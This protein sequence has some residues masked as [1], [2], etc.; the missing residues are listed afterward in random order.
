MITLF[1]IVVLFIIGKELSRID[2]V[3]LLGVFLIHTVNIFKRRKKYK[4]KKIEDEKTNTSK[5]SWLLI[6]TLA[7]I[8]LFIAS[9]FVVKYASK[10]AF[11]LNLPEILI[12]LFLISFATTLPELVF[13]LSAAKLKHKE[14]AI[15][16]QIGSVVTNTGLILGIV[17][18]IHPITAE[19]KPFLIS[20]IFMFIAGF[21]FYTFI[22]SKKHLAKNEGISL[23]LIY[24]LFVIMNFLLNKYP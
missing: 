23:I 1:L 18:I 21:I 24:I 3:I 4:K 20:S 7:F 17:A 2:G 10:L 22:K 8:G 5:F 9:N 16:N 12:G 14:M 11:D 19:F 15:G 6:F 13:G